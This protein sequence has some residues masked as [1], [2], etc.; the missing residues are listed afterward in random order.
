MTQDIFVSYAQNREDVML[1]RA[2]RDVG[3]GFYIDAGA[4]DPDLLSVTRAFYERG[5]RGVN[6]EPLPEQAARLRQAR[7]RDVVVEAALLD[8]PGEAEFYR[9]RHHGDLGLSSLDPSVAA[10]SYDQVEA[11]TVRATTLAALCRAHVPGEVHFLKLDVEGAERAVLAGADFTACRPWIVL[12]E[13]TRPLSQ[14]STAAEWEDLLLQAGYQFVWF[15]GLNRFYVA[16]ERHGALARHFQVCPNVF[17]NYLVAPLPAAPAP[18]PPA[19]PQSQPQ[20]QPQPEAAPPPVPPPRPAWRRAAVV[21]SAPVRRL[22]RPL[23]WRARTF[24]T[25]GLLDEIAALRA[26]QAVMQAQLDAMA[27]AMATAEPGLAAEVDRLLLT[28][29]LERKS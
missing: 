21:T 19:P 6:I 9:V 13:A 27:A 2:L 26:Q 4:A 10:R 7:P 29:E 23:A 12:V 8:A 5:W 20:P 24:L 14:D 17:D 11:L 18:E 16:Q 15:D 25:G 28:L 3:P 22:L 1:W